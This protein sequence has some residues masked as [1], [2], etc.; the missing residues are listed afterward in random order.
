M[1]AD[2]FTM[3]AKTP[4]KRPRRAGANGHDPPIF[5]HRFV[6]LLGGVLCDPVFFGIH[7]VLVVMLGLIGLNVP[8]PMSRR[9]RHS[10]T[11]C[12]S[13]CSKQFLGKVHAA[14]GRRN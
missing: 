6:D 8:L 9:M 3:F 5:F 14:V 10:S 11:P 7:L 13:S 4:F 2:D 1:C 12:L